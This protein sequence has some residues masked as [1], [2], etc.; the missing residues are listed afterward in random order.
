VHYGTNCMVLKVPKILVITLNVGTV[1]ESEKK[2]QCRC[3]S[4]ELPRKVNKKSSRIND[5]V[6]ALGRVSI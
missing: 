2:E 5:V 6:R 1:P 3:Y 4:K